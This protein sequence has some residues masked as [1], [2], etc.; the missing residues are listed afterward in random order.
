MDDKGGAPSENLATGVA[1]LI[2]AVFG[3]GAAVARATAEATGRGAKCPPPEPGAASFTAMVH[4]GVI[5]A[6]NMISLVSG[7]AGRVPKAAPSNAASKPSE[8]SIPRVRPG[9]KLRVPLSIENPSDRPML[10]LSPRLRRVFLT[11]IESPAALSSD[12]VQF[13]PA[14]LDVLPRDFEKLTVSVTVPENAAAGRYDLI[15]ALGPSEPDLP[16][17][18]EVTPANAT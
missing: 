10:G 9:A 14:N 8:R 5:A 2:D 13:I 17:T 18:F 11:G 3:V 4:Y 1:Q 7:A 12:A 15:L 16:F 6:G